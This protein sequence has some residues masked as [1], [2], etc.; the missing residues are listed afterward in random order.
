MSSSGCAQTP[1]IVPRSAT[2]IMRT[3]ASGATGDAARAVPLG[4]RGADPLADPLGQSLREHFAA[5]LRRDEDLHVFLE[6]GVVVAVAASGE[7]RLD[8]DREL[9]ETLAVDV[10]L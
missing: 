8:L 9:A 10:A 7:V 5:T 4:A 6:L 1:R 3:D 2:S